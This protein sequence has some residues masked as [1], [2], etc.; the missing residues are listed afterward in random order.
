MK[1][2]EYKGINYVVE[3][4]N[5]EK[6]SL[7]FLGWQYLLDSRG[8]FELTFGD[9]TIRV[10][11]EGETEKGDPCYLVQLRHEDWCLKAEGSVHW[12]QIED[13]AHTWLSE[14]RSFVQHL[15]PDDL[16]EYDVWE[17]SNAQPGGEEL[18]WSDV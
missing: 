14:M 11:S 5:G 17:P 15:D 1:T 6:W 12:C 9:W 10:S 2:H 3:T 16:V 13:F 8:S 7:P 4:D 18:G